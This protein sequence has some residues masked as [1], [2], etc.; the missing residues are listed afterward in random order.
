MEK[1][2]ACTRA[3]VGLQ[4]ATGPTGLYAREDR[5][6]GRYHSHPSVE[7][8]VHLELPP[9]GACYANRWRSLGTG[10]MSDTRGSQLRRPS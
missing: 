4:D 5:E 1:G 8:H 6:R 2:L 3:Y 7:A 9:T 10:E